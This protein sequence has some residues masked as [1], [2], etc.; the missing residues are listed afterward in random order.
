MAKTTRGQIVNDELTYGTITIEE[1]KTAISDTKKEIASGLDKWKV[2]HVKRLGLGNIQKKFNHWYV[3]GIPDDEK[4]CRTILLEKSGD[5]TDVNNWRPITIGSILLRL[6]C[7]IWDSRLRKKV[8]INPRQKA[9]VPV[10]GCYENVKTLQNVIRHY[11]KSKKELNIVFLDLSKAFDTVLKSSVMKALIRKGVPDDVRNLIDDLYTNASTTITNGNGSTRR[12]LI[13]SGVKQG[14]PLSPFLFNLVMDELLDDIEAMGIGAKIDN[15]LIPIMGFAN[16]LV[17][18]E[19]TEFGMKKLLDKCETF[20]D[21]KGLSVNA[22]KSLSLRTL[23]VKSKRSFKVVEEAHRWWKGV[24]LP[25]A[26]HNKLMRY[27]GV[28][29]NPLGEVVLPL[30]LWETWFERIR[31]TPLKPAQRIWS[32]RTI[33]IPRMMHQL[34]L[35]DVGISKLKVIN[36]LVRKNFKL[37]LHLPEWTPDCWILLR[38]GGNL[39]DLTSAILKARKKASTKMA[40]S[41]DNATA[42]VGTIY[43]N[44]NDDQLRKLGLQDHSVSETSKKIQQDAVDKLLAIINGEALLCMSQSTV[45]R[46][47]LWYSKTIQGGDVVLAARMLS[48]T[49]PTKLNLSRGTKGERNVLCR[50]C[51]LTAETDIHIF[52]VCISTKLARCKRHNNTADKIAKELKKVQ[53]LYKKEHIEQ[54]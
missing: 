22:K 13:N 14:C 20:F 6:F 50:K 24:P 18:L 52:N 29:L 42:V 17:L 2:E 48:G 36:R 33:I 53:R 46:D 37:F 28:N 35:A 41:N 54:D 7:K 10:D 9:F 25:S 5:L 19:E 43:D 23:P 3:Y 31:R 40:T 27:L 26:D 44:K 32:I 16:D 11:N 15:E 4:E 8:S 51:H 49:L 47:W 30:D 34:R 45:K 38:G 21:Q 12:I 1:V 39:G